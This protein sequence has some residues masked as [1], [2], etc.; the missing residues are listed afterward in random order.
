MDRRKFLGMVPGVAAVAAAASLPG[1]AAH[2]LTLQKLDEMIDQVDMPRHVI[3]GM[4]SRVSMHAGD[5]AMDQ[6][7]N[8]FFAR[9]IKEVR[10]DGKK[11]EIPMLTVDVKRGY[12]LS[13][14]M[15]PILYGKQF[16]EVGVNA[17]EYHVPR[18]DLSADLVFAVYGK[19]EII[20]D[21]EA[22]NATS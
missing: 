3:V 17:M 15:Q 1:E 5:P 2:A 7:F 14:A 21:T 22:L 16:G 8:D 6:P 13:Y 9:H 11:W 18:S 12:I 19:V 20:W 10:L 4:P